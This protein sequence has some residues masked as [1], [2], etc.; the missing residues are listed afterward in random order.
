LRQTTITLNGGLSLGNT[1]RDLETYTI[2]LQSDLVWDRDSRLSLGVMNFHDNVPEPFDLSDDINIDSGSYS[3]TTGS[4]AYS[5]PAVSF[6]ILGLNARGGTFYDGILKSTGI[7]PQIV[8]SKYFQ[9]SAFYQF[10]HIDFKEL[11]QTFISHLTRLNLTGSVNVKL[12]LSAFVQ[13]NSLD[14]IGAINFRLRYNPVDG[15]DLYIVY[16]EATNTDPTS[17]IPNLPVSDS[18]VLIVKYIHTFRL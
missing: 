4:V 13:F 11:D 5:T 16:N 8:F 3:N 12:S 6:F 9:L 10:T 17:I 7:E 15:N 1:S 2:G 18:R 14:E